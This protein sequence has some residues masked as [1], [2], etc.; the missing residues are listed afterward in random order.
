MRI[1]LADQEDVVAPSRD[2]FADHRLGAAFAVHLGGVDQR[3]AEVEPELER[4]DL[5]VELRALLAHA[6]GALAEHGHLA[7]GGKW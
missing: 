1:D 4:R 2:R 3:D 6:P 7:A 5:G